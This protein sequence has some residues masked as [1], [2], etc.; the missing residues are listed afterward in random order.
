M[1]LCFGACA[2]SDGGGTTTPAA[3]TVTF[4]PSSNLLFTTWSATLTPTTTGTISSCTISPSLP[5]GLSLDAT[6]CAISGTPTASSAAT[7]YTVT[8]SNSG[9]TS[10]ATVTIKVQTNTATRAYGQAS[11]TTNATGTTATT[12]NS[13]RYL[14][15]SSTGVYSSDYWNHRVLYYAGTSTTATRVYGQGG[16]FTVGTCNNGGRSATSLC[17]ANGIAVDASENVWIVDTGNNRVLWFAPGSTTATGVYGQTGFTTGST[18]CTAST[19]NQPTAVW[20]DSTG[21]YI[22]D[23]A[24]HRVVYYAGLTNPG[25]SGPSATRIYGQP[26][27]TTCTQNTGGRSETSLFNPVNGYA[28]SEGV[29]I[30]DDNNNRVLYFSGTS[31]TA[32][33]VYGQ[34]SFTAAATAVTATGLGSPKGVFAS[35]EGV[36]IA[37][38]YERVLFYPG[39]STTATVALGQPNFTSSAGNNGGRSATSLSGVY[40]VLINNGMWIADG[41]NNRVLFFP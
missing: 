38:G 22:A 18:G 3:P 31:T 8:A 25:T 5:A 27:A 12:L 33:R 14:A 17:N 2:K 6:T 10:T 11:F 40:A 15:V 39:T 23:Q 32:T 20:L 28:T 34:T 19:L 26:N 21:V 35:G 4:T 30:A 1:A 9:T 41:N 36:L 7:S 24:N 16:S 13:P 29:Y 37:D